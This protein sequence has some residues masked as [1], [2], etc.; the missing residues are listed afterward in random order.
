MSRRSV[1]EG[2]TGLGLR[3]RKLLGR[4]EPSQVAFNRDGSPTW[5]QGSGGE[6]G[7]IVGVLLEDGSVLEF[8][9]LDPG[10]PDQY[11]PD[12]WSNGE[13]DDLPWS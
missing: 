6:S 11:P 10:R 1:Y 9:R 4:D 12:M 5:V 3:L 7:R 13:E 8:P 2:R